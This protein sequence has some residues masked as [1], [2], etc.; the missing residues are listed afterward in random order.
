MGLRYTVEFPDGQG[1]YFDVSEVLYYGP[2]Q[3]HEE[4]GVF[5]TTDGALVLVIDGREQSQTDSIH[6]YHAGLVGAVDSQL[7]I[8]EEQ[9]RSSNK[10]SYPIALILGSGPGAAAHE[11]LQSKAFARANSHIIQVDIDGDIIALSKKHLRSW[12]NGC[13]N[14]SRISTV[15]EDAVAF[16]KRAAIYGPFDVIIYDLT[17]P[18]SDHNSIFNREFF[19]RCYDLL[20]IGGVFC[21]QV[22][23]AGHNGIK[24]VE[25]AVATLESAGFNG[26]ILRD[27]ISLWTFY[28]AKK[29]EKLPF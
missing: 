20:S 25:T 6:P 14:D 21:A 24:Q 18:D 27:P 15:V 12:H 1:H 2:T 10:R 23:Y 13:F 16:V 7:E 9:F 28:H 11:L 8:Q 5:R 17:E 4:V 3:V 29:T 19:I 22:G 26:T